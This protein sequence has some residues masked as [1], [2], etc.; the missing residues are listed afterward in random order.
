MDKK[1]RLAEHLAHLAA[2]FFNRESNRTSLITVTRA[3]FTDRMARITIFISVFPEK[4]EN[5][6]L[7]FAK[8][9]AGEFR[10][11]LK[12]VARIQHLPH[13]DM[14]LD[15]GEKNRLRLE[16]LT[17]TMPKENE[18]V[19]PEHKKVSAEKPAPKKPR[20]KNNT[21]KKVLASIKAKKNKDDTDEDDE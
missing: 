15:Y 1:V 11:Y 20:I 3:E 7:I 14:Q 21:S 19:G 4:S 12:T 8:R 6:S 9:Y 17:R 16:A 13:I 2:E 18:V 10:E 5:D